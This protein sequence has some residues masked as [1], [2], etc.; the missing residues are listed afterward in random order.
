M[1]MTKNLLRNLFRK[2]STR[3]YPVVAR[4]DYEGFRG[5]LHNDIEKCIFCK[6]CA[7][8]CPSQCI[9]VD[10]KEGVWELDVMACVYCSV[11]VETCPVKC[12]SMKAAYRKPFVGRQTQTLHGT[13]K[14]AKKA[15]K[16]EDAAP[17]AESAPDSAPA[18]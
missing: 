12:L 10:S 5:E 3:L 18:E 6:A 15:A 16:T 1:F 2:K 4:P 17:A 14:A 9:K 8:K 7:M 11:C 13:P